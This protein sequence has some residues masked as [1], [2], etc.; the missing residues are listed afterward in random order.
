MLILQILVFFLSRLI[1]LTIIPIFTDEAIYIRWAQIAF[2][3]GVPFISLTDGKQVLMVWLMMITQRLP[4]STLT[5][6]R[7]VSVLAGLISL[8]VLGKLMARIWPGK[9]R[10]WLS[11]LIYTL[12]PF[13]IF[14]DRLAIYD[15][16]LAATMI[17]CLYF[18]VVLVQT[19]SLSSALALGI[20]LGL[21]RL[22]K[23]SALFAILLLPLSLLLLKA[24]SKKTWCKK[25]FNWTVWA[26]LAVVISEVI[27]SVQRLS[28]AYYMIGQKNNTFIFKLS[29]FMADPFNR[30][31]GNLKGMTGWLTGFLTWP[32]VGLI[33]IS[34]LDYKKKWR[35][36]L[37]FL[38][39]FI[40]PF[41][42]LA[43]FGRV[44]FPRFILFMSMSLM[45]LAAD[46]L[47]LVYSQFKKR[48]HKLMALIVAGLILLW[49]AY[50]S[51]NLLTNSARANIPS[52]AKNQYI[53]SWPSGS[54][55]PQL[56]DYLQKASQDQAV[57][58]ATEGTFGLMPYAL[59]IYFYDQPQVTVK[60]YW[61]INQ[62]PAEVADHALT[63][64]TYFLFYQRENPPADWP[65][66][67]VFEH[68]KADPTY[69]LR[70]YRVIN[71]EN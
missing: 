37:L 54:G 4:L 59:E 67:L 46:G 50:I 55:V 16:L 6:S 38:A 10:I 13:Y 8:I 65:L 19:P 25:A 2:D 68:Y 11:R 29:E 36:K 48:F 71:E 12:I 57:F 62:L 66:Q 70:L 44:I 20:G 69:P 49:P 34:L 53:S 43:F 27:Q 42:S 30:L 23:S 28:S 15:S 39:W 52:A 47:F 7:L 61:P 5:A 51:W 9:T 3:S 21:A 24:K 63:Q 18:E 35:V 1:N 45:P 56:V 14:Y 58:V 31:L 33:I 41:F 40:F 26:G 64:P 32:I 60:G 22:V 17:L